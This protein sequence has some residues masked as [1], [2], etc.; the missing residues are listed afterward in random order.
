MPLNTVQVEYF[1]KSLTQSRK[2]HYVL[3]LSK[4]I[5]TVILL[6]A[7]TLACLLSTSNIAMG[8]M[9]LNFSVN[10]ATN[11]SF[12]PGACNMSDAPNNAIEPGMC[13][14]GNMMTVNDPDDTRFYHGTYTDP[15][16]NV[17]YWHTI[18]GDP[19]TGFAMESYIPRINLY[20]STSGGR[21]SRIMGWDKP[22]ETFSGNGWDPLGINPSRDFDFTGNGTADPTR[23]IVRQIM[24]GTW[25]ST[26][27]T[28]SCDSSDAYCSEFLKDQLQL[29][30]KITQKINDTEME[31]N[32]ILDMSSITYSD[33]TTAGN[34]INTL[35]IT[36]PD[37]PDFD[38]TA[39]DFQ[40]VNNTITI[41][42]P[43]TGLSNLNPNVTGGRYIYNQCADTQL[44]SGVEHCWQS[45][46]IN[47]W[48]Y[49]E[50]SYSYVNGGE[51][52]VL[53]YEW[54][55]YWD[56]AQNNGISGN[57]SKCLNGMGANSC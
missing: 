6:K 20:E 13:G 11:N 28:W 33:D 1:M 42:H 47:A 2:S 23:V 50:G 56:P 57:E 26:T 21:P 36:D 34:I 37:M 15:D 17:S 3:A 51:A 45:T 38:P 48:D 25:N 46:D 44:S 30:P 49:Q 53:N 5:D 55:L 35:A 39:G 40:M 7:V 8:E 10:S 29:K 22:L 43:T 14:I 41:S 27:K 16:T 12:A 19:N 52:D 4:K 32:F 24:G 9:T 31:Q 54:D 18:V